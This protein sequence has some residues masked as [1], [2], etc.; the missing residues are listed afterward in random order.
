MNKHL[1]CLP[2]LISV[3]ISIAISA[4]VQAQTYAS[5]SE[6]TKPIPWWEQ[7]IWGN[8]NR[9][10]FWYGPRKSDKEF[11]EEAPKQASVV[12]KEVSQLE[13]LQKDVEQLKAVAV[14]NP[15]PT[16]VKNF[17][18]KQQQVFA[19]SQKF[20]DVFQK[21]VFANPQL[22]NTF[23]GRPVAPLALT[24][25]ED[26][27]RIGQQNRL[28]TIGHSY[29]MYFFF[30]SDCP[31]CH[32]FAPIVKQFS[33]QYGMTVFPVS[34]DGKGLPEYPSPITDNGVARTLGV[35]AVPSVFLA[36]PQTGNIIP[37]GAGMMSFSE[38]QQRADQNT[39]PN[40]Q[41]SLN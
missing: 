8:P 16:N 21:V 13:K 22:D 38:L 36:S 32:A 3:A 15:T 6:Q 14:V 26:E 17:L 12:P 4:N 33:E 5:S 10:Y 25:Y 35:S 37:L 9:D 41:P 39:R 31:Y 23:S 28:K 7:S 34:T 19:L 29:G 24:V 1:F 2:L 27:Q 18:E 11:K 40:P 30:R 20:A